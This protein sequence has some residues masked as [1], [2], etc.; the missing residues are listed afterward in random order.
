MIKNESIYN[1]KETFFWFPSVTMETDP[2]S[3]IRPDR[4]KCAEFVRN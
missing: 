2:L 3:F 1:F 4:Q